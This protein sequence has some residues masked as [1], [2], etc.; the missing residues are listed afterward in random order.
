MLPIFALAVLLAIYAL[1]EIVAQKTKAVLS[2]TLVIALVLLVGFWCGLPPTIF[3]DAAIPGAGMLLVGILITSLGTRIDFAELRRQWKTVIIGVVGVSVAVAGIIL[4]GQFV[5]GRDMAMAGAPIFAGANTASLVMIDALGKKGLSE[6][7]TFCILML[8]TQNFVGIPVASQLL[9]KEAK[10]MLAR[11]D[12]L[13]LYMHTQAEAEEAKRRKPLQLPEMFAKPSVYLC[14]LALVATV[15]NVLASLTKG[16]IHYFVFALLLGILFYELGFLEEDSLTKSHASTFILFITTV[17]IF[18]NLANTTPQ[19]V[20]S[21]LPA[22]LLCLGIGVV[23][24]V[25][26]GFVL[27]KVLKVGTGLSISIILTCTFGF[28]TTLFMP[29]EVA[30]AIGRTDEEKAALRN[31]LE[32]KMITGGFVT[33]TI[34]S[35]IL[36]GIVAGML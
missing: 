6:L 10:D 33:V 19:Q 29:Q 14:K 34:F 31:Y 4:V 21:M 15:A 5:I 27:A 1:G 30:Q 8:V 13:R 3:D 11:P 24:A 23:F 22:L 36:A 35:V 32:P 26:A 7:S 2:M 20:L 17:V 9:R 28:P 16:K 18:T 12:Q 25:A